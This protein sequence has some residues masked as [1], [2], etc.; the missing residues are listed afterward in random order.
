M[1]NYTPHVV[2]V[3]PKI[4]KLRQNLQ[5]KRTLSNKTS[6]QTIGIKCNNCPCEKT[7]KNRID[8]D[9]A[10]VLPIGDIEMLAEIL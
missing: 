10:D 6:M 3:K 2:A 5:T 9:I 1:I 8:A 4:C 7:G